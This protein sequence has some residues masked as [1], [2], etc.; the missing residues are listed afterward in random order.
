MALRLLHRE[1]GR[2]HS[3]EVSATRQIAKVSSIDAKATGTTSLYTA[4]QDIIVLAV[5]ISCDSAVDI[6]APARGGVG[7]AAG[8]D[9]ICESQ[10]FYGLTATGKQFYFP[11]DGAGAV[12]SSGQEIKLG[13]D[14][15]ATGTSQSLT[16]EVI[17]YG[18]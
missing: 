4:S 17:G 5:V 12:V 7:V 13:I 11:N 9:D 16:A 15:A 8:E 3:A 10:P 14:V 18:V 1:P 2:A 6:T